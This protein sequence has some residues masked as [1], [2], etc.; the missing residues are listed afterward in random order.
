M[1]RKKDG[2]VSYVDDELFEAIAKAMT[3]NKHNFES[4]KLKYMQWLEQDDFILEQHQVSK[5]DWL[6]ALNLRAGVHNRADKK[7]VIK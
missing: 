5:K 3:I 6:H 2:T 1:K 7:V 4:N